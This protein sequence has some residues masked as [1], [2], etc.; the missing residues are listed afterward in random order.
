MD[1]I[2]LV[3]YINLDKRPDRKAELER[4]LARLEIPPH[5]ILRWPGIASL[6]GAL[7]CS[8]SHI[9]LLE[10]ILTLPPES[11][12]NVLILEDDFNFI[13][14]AKLVKESITKFLDEA[15]YP[16][17][18]WDA[19]LLAHVSKATA[20]RDEFISTMLRCEG[21]GG[22]LLNRRVIPGILAN[23]KEGYQLLS[24]TRDMSRYQ[25][26]NH[27]SQY[28]RASQKCAFFNKPLGYQRKSY[29]NISGRRRVRMSS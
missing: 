4:E 11:T 3:A 28:M 21:T 27:W 10:H 20:P 22:F 15:Q 16:R 12:R 13:D 24:D 5:K 26:D 7:G 29:S 8:Q 6:N 1:S 9:G 18:T 17:D 14:D 25:I 2:D 23:F 19:I